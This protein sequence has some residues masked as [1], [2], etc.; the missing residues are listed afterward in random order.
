MI[1]PLK[2]TESGKI[3][4]EMSP[5]SIIAAGDLLASLQLAVGLV[6]CCGRCCCCC[7]IRLLSVLLL[8]RWA[9]VGVV[10]AAAAAAV[11]AAASA[12]GRFAFPSL[13]FLLLLRQVWSTAVGVASSTAGYDYRTRQVL[14]LLLWYVALGV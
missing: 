2:A 4:H 5:G 10:A 9:V 13:L 8:L 14:R 6:C 1:M 7:C 11:P 12:C 3:S